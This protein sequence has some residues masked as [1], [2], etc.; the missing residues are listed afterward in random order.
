MISIAE[1]ALK[2]GERGVVIGQT[3]T[4][5]SYL[6]SALLPH[7]GDLCIVDPKREFDNLEKLPVYSSVKKIAVYRPKRFV[8]RPSERDIA[9][10]SLYDDLFAY[11]YKRGKIFI[12]VDEVA[13]IGTANRYPHWLLVCYQLGRSKGITILC[14]SQRPRRVPVFIFSEAQRFYVFRLTTRQDVQTV[15]EYAK[16]YGDVTLT[17]PHAFAYYYNKSRPFQD[18]VTIM[19]LSKETKK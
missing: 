5:K 7:E 8:F 2:P 1:I 6:S 14:C 10:L 11:L 15:S 17:N 12:Y 19:M 4:G 16:G 3:G 18:A 13:I 9:N